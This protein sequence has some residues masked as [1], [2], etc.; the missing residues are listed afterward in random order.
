M[1]GKFGKVSEIR[2]YSVYNNY[3]LLLQILVILFESFFETLPKDLPSIT[4]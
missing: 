2:V 3:D 4:I 1:I